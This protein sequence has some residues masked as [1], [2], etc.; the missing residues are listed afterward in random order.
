[1]PAFPAIEPINR[2]YGLGA[3]PVV[4]EAFGNSGEV[5]FLQCDTLS[6]VPVAL[7]FPALT[8]SEAATIR[9]HYLGQREHR[10]FIIPAAL[11]RSHSS[12]FN[13]VPAANIWRYAGPPVETP[14]SGELVDVSVSLVSAYAPDAAR[15]INGGALMQAPGLGTG[16]VVGFFLVSGGTFTQAP[17]L[18]PG[19]ASLAISGGTF[20]QTPSLAPGAVEGGSMVTFTGGTALA[21]NDSR[22]LDAAYGYSF[23]LASAKTIKAVGF[24][25]AGGNGLT[26]A[27]VIAVATG[28]GSTLTFSNYI[29]VTTS[30]F[31]YVIVPSGTTA[32]LDGVWRKVEFSDGVT[33]QAGTY[34]VTATVDFEGP[35]G[36]TD[37]LIK[38]ATGVT[39]AAGVTINGPIATDGFDVLSSSG[40]SP[41]YFG[42]VLFF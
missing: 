9:D 5:R 15:I 6:G 7:D 28:W 18:T 20:T 14:R 30:N 3:H 25:D 26:R 27:F 23:T 10:P 8:T 22:G 29:P 1:M 12:Q 11:W 36:T 16:V 42:P 35:E 31:F 19:V 13:T 38:N 24:Y 17:S 39:A 21:W 37:S 33:L 40:D 41:A 2:G 34:A 4:V 32:P